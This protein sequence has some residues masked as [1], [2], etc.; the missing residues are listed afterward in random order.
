VYV[1]SS[2]AS[3]GNITPEKRLKSSEAS[4]KSI[5]YE[6][7]IRNFAKD[8]EFLDGDVILRFTKDFKNSYYSMKKAHND[9]EKFKELVG[10]KQYTA[11]MSSPDSTL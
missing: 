3:S 10:E 8:N 9:I 5:K 2:R 4:R 11:N 6:R 1:C 7:K